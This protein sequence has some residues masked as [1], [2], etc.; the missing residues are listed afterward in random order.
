MNLFNYKGKTLY[1]GQDVS[2]IYQRNGKNKTI[3][4]R[5]FIEK[6]DKSKHLY[7]F[8]NTVSGYHPE[9]KHDIGEFKC[10]WW[11]AT[12]YY[13]ASGNKMKYD[14][15]IVDIYSKTDDYEII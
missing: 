9:T 3:K 15:S 13:K 1:Q 5:V 4:G 8:N 7:L 14:D 11:A 2:F 12:D 6:I 10:S